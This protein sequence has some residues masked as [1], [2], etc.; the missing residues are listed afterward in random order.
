MI[1]SNREKEEYTIDNETHLKMGV[2]DDERVL[3]DIV[4][5]MPED[6]DIFS[7]NSFKVALDNESGKQGSLAVGSQPGQK[8][9][10]LN[11]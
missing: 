3:Q 1:L 5:S 7:V 11:A 6:E 10:T 9:Q 2:T 8:S 4:P